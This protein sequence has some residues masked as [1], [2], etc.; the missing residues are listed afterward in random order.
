MIIKGGGGVL[1]LIMR[2]FLKLDKQT[3][4]NYK[5][6]YKRYGMY[7]IIYGYSN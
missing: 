7:S 5:L 4:I 6:S 1:C 3:Q 2:N